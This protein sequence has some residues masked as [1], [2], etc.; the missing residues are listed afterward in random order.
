MYVPCDTDNDQANLEVYIDVLSKI[1]H[2][3]SNY[4]DVNHTIIAGGLNTEMTR[5]NALHT[6][7]LEEY[8]KNQGLLLCSSCTDDEVLFIHIN[9]FTA[10][11]LN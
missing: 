5:R 4:I 10:L 3:H 7:A 2:V 8:M 9:E 6:I 11:D 1:S